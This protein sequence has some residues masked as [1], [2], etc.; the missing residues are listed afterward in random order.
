MYG[1]R[2]QPSSEP[3]LKT[4]NTRRLRHRLCGLGI[5]FFVSLWRT[6]MIRAAGF[7][8]LMLLSSS[9][10]PLA[11]KPCQLRPGRP[12]Y[13]GG[14]C[15]AAAPL[16]PAGGLLPNIEIAAAPR[17]R[18]GGRGR[19]ALEAE[20]DGRGSGSDP[21]RD[22]EDDASCVRIC[23]YKKFFYEGATNSLT[24]S[25]SHTSLNTSFGPLKTRSARFKPIDSITLSHCSGLL[26]WGQAGRG[27]DYQISRK[28]RRDVT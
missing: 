4:P 1:N 14:M 5:F 22:R 12:R 23:R 3:G 27:R 25:L 26:G 20:A 16:L 21:E 8:V 24:H 10:P 15:F 6:E 7:G 17:L 19:C 9:L 18:R 13:E 28:L 11:A 2:L